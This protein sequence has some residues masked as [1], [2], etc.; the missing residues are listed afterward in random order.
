M[1]SKLVYIIGAIIIGLASTTA[2]IFGLVGGDVIEVEK[3]TIV[4]ESASA[5]AV[6][7]G[8]QL[9]CSDYEIV[10]G[11]LKEGHTANVVVYG[12]QTNVGSSQNY[13]SI[14]ITDTNGTDVSEYYTIET[15]FG[16]LSV[17]KAPLIIISKSK[18]KE[19]DGKPL[20]M[21]DY[22]LG[23]QSKLAANHKVVCDYTTNIVNVG[24]AQNTFS[25]KVYD[26]L[27]IDVTANYDISKI[28]GAL[29]VT[30][31][32]ITVESVSN[33]K[34][35]DGT[36]LKDPSYTIDDNALINGH[37][38]VYE[39][40]SSITNVGII[41]NDFTCRI[42]DKDHNDV[43][44][45]YEITYIK[46]T[47][48][49]AVRA[50]EIL[51]GSD[52]KVYSG[53]P[54]KVESYSIVSGEVLPE[55][56]LTVV[57]LNSITNVGTINNKVT[58][59]IVDADGNDV[60]A[61]YLITTNEGTLTITQ[62]PITIESDDKERAFNG[63][64]LQ[65]AEGD[66]HLKAGSTLAD[67]DVL[68]PSSTNKI[69]H[70]GSVPFDFTY[71][72]KD[73]EGNNVTDNYEVNATIGKLTVK[74]IE[75]TLETISRTKD[76]DGVALTEDVTITTTY[77]AVL[78]DH[79]LT[80]TANGSQTTVGQT[81]NT[82]THTILDALGEDI[83]KDYNFTIIEGTLEVTP[84]VLNITSDDLNEVYNGTEFTKHSYYLTDSS[85]AD[86]EH[87]EIVYTGRLVNAGIAENTFTIKIY[88]GVGYDNDVTSNYDINRVFGTITVEKRA[89]KIT[90]SEGITKTY[91]YNATDI[92]DATFVLYNDPADSNDGIAPA[93][94]FAPN[95]SSFGSI[96]NVGSMTNSFAY[97]IL[98]N[99][100]SA[101]REG[102]PVINNYI[103][104]EEFGTIVVKPVEITIKVHSDTKQYD[105]TPIIC[106]D[107]TKTA[108]NFVADH[109]L[110]YNTKATSQITNVGKVDNVPDETTIV[111]AGVDGINVK[112]NY[113]I[114]FEKDAEGSTVEITAKNLTIRTNDKTE[115]YKGHAIT[116]NEYA[117]TL[118]EIASTD[119]LV[120]TIDGNLDY[121]GET[122]NTFAGVSVYRRGNNSTRTLTIKEGESVSI[123]ST[124]INATFTISLIGFNGDFSKYYIT[125]TNGVIT[126]KGMA[127][128]TCFNE[129]LEG[130]DPSTD[131][132]VVSA[133]HDYNITQNVGK[134]ILVYSK[135][136]TGLSQ[137]EENMA[138]Y[139]V[140]QVKASEDGPV[141]LRS[142]SYTKYYGNAWAKGSEYTEL[143]D[144]TYSY[145]YLTSA[146][147][148]ADTL[149]THATTTLSIKLTSAPYVIP[150]YSEMS[151][152]QDTIQTSD[153]LY[154]GTH[155]EYD[156]N[157]YPLT[158]TDIKSIA[159]DSS[160]AYKTQEDAYYAYVSS[161][162][163]YLQ[164][165]SDLQTYLNTIISD[166]SLNTGDVF[167]TIDKV[168]A[169]VST[170]AKY[171]ISYNRLLDT[172]AD[173]VIAFLGT[174][175]EG[176][177]SHF[178]E[179]TTMLLRALGIPARYVSGYYSYGV[180]DEWVSITNMKKHAWT[181]VY[182]E[183]IGWV[184]I[185]ATAGGVVKAGEDPSTVDKSKTYTVRPVSISYK[186]PDITTGNEKVLVATN[187]LTGLEEIEKLGYTYKKVVIANKT[188]TGFGTQNTYPSEFVILDP[189]GRDVTSEFKI[190]KNYG[191]LQIYLNEIGIQ[192]GSLTG[193]EYDGTAHTYNSIKINGTSISS[194][195]D[196]NAIPNLLDT[197]DGHHFTAITTTGS[198][199]TVGQTINAVSYRIED[200]DGN[201]VSSYYIITNNFGIIE[202][203][204][205]EITLTAGSQNAVIPFADYDFENP[206]TIT[207]HSYTITDGSLITGDYI[208]DSSINYS[209][210]LIGVGTQENAIT[211]VIIRNASGDDVTSNYKITTISGTLTCSI[212]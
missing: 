146:A 98:T 37:F 93:D 180:K 60:R 161:T 141:Y 138:E 25:V 140:L 150:Y 192:S 52:S 16:T 107:Y 102:E 49:V 209:G 71:E 188:Q 43:T 105:G 147:I 15:K 164:I 91:T 54:L 181:E 12:S 53:S 201:D 31:K 194:V 21:K 186:A 176:V 157:Y 126:L 191:K 82:I 114:T 7:D 202:V 198:Q 149:A 152:S 185:D 75:I 22:E 38:L 55:D 153:V 136:Y 24:I 109:V 196:A 44:S 86:N 205:R 62:K 208:V 40:N 57:Y 23:S 85:F 173:K 29:T 79:T 14:T 166:E 72:I 124:P 106:T 184:Q 6:Y 172:Q 47:L 160:Y 63:E 120:V 11:A 33:G 27:D 90:T 118:G 133:Y 13:M 189:N 99:T 5:T 182:L 36:E 83:S 130:F 87:A 127:D 112:D 58:Y 117:I 56:T 30:P 64:Y 104:T 174:Y 144:D 187:Q 78:A 4:F 158:Y 51:T 101:Y 2:I 84:R 46:G 42:E 122:D 113:K 69:L 97:N 68:Y 207:E 96:K 76:Y 100:D 168:I 183:N 165:T 121:I 70:V 193:I 139:E 19:F 67:G 39:N 155:S 34:I 137:D 167:T 94:Q 151:L 129:V 178:A 204:E 32:N 95:M 80:A 65:Y 125:A 103:I 142:Y 163:K 154:A 108:G 77:G 128:A 66:I 73:S 89:L 132:D 148:A 61:N 190:V 18:G 159:L 170:A 111:I 10:D 179:A 156:V 169:Y 92:K 123:D 59:T 26:E 212:S 17:E 200:T 116:C 195:S 20:E 131:I 35:Y 199:T 9:T 197:A 143:L 48:Q 206:P 41:P 177:C 45:N 210:E 81:E 3:T 115:E 8:T 203:V 134:L 171:N 211:G 50:L 110:S 145:N 1:K 135:E 119:Y 162:E 175:K 74:P 88:H 28:Y